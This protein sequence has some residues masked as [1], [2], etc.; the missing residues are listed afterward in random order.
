MILFLLA[1]PFLFY[2]FGREV[3]F[4][5]KGFSLNDSRWIAFII[6]FIVFFPVQFIAFRLFNSF[7][8]YLQTLEHELTHLFVGLFFLKIPTGIRVTAHD[9]G[10]VRQVGRGTTGQTWISL[11]PYFFPTVSLAII[12]FAYFLEVKTNILLGLLGF[13]TAFHLISNWT[14]TSFRQTD[15]QDAGI[16][17]TILI[18]PIMNLICYGSVL[19]FVKRGSSGFVGF[20]VESLR[21][22]YEFGMGVFK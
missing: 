16:V 6:G 11:A 1:V 22:A 5:L 18:L 13:S 3:L 2:G 10:E 4:V 7:W 8:C 20:W 12:I 17:K 9:G 19:A 21:A 14:Q 15:L